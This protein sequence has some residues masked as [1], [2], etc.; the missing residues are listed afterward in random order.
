MGSGLLMRPP[1][2]TPIQRAQLAHDLGQGM[3][4]PQRP[5][6]P[7]VWLARLGALPLMC[8]PGARWM[9]HT[10]ADV[11]GVLIARASGQ[12]LETFLR[13]HIFEPL[14]MRDTGF[15]VPPASRA[16][17]TTGYWTDPATGASSIYDAPQ[18]A[19]STPPAFPSAG[20]GLVS[21][22]EDL[23]A[24]AHMMLGGGVH[25]G[26]R[27]LS[28]ASVE[29][30][31]TNQLSAAE[32]ADAEFV[33]GFFD[34][35]GWGFGMT[36]VAERRQLG[37]GPGSYGWNGGL[38]TAWYNDPHAQLAAVILTQQAFS[39]PLPPAIVRDFFALAAAAFED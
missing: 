10:G 12:P 26:D 13:E 11:L 30:M 9:Y 19:W 6:A 35:R 18:G 15:H 7:D 32:R 38:G 20:A 29:L 4:A 23:E 17:F 3:P 34:D 27:I 1:D 37:F 39:T 14:G 25:G 16:R 22:I 28:R 24:F 36:V 5:P 31:T 8:Q 2:A 33:P 21:T